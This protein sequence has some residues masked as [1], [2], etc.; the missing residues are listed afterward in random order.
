MLL[1][2]IAAVVLFSG[3]FLSCSKNYLDI[4]DKQN[5]TEQSFWQTRQNALEG[6]TATYAALQGYDGSKWTFFEEIYTTLT[7][8]SDDIEN[9]TV[10]SYGKSIASFTDGTDVSGVWNL[11]TTCYVGIGRANQVLEKV[12]SIEAMTEQE[13]KEIVG[14]ARFLRAYF[15]FVLING[16]ENVPLVLATEKDINKLKV[17]QASPDE[18]WTQIENDLL[19][20]EAALPSSYD[21][22]QIGRATQG[23]AKAMLGKVYLFREKWQAAETKFKELDGKYSL[24]NNY[25]DNFTGLRENSSESVFEIQFSGDRTLSDEMHPFNYEVRPYAI[26]GWELFYPSNWLVAEMKKDTTASGAYSSRVYNSIFFDDPQSKIWDLN[27]PA[28]EVSYSSLAG[29]LNHPHYFKKYAYPYDRSGSYTGVN[30]SLIRYADVLLMLAEALNENGK[31]DDA[32]GRINEVRARSGTKAI[33]NGSLTQAE[34]RELLRNH[35][36]PVELSMEFGIRWFDL[37]RWAK[38]ATAP[39]SIKSVLTIHNK[40]AA[41]NFIDNKHIRY[42]IPALERAVNPNLIQNNGY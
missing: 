34:C 40:P 11:W 6:I 21:D 42:A 37:I 26:D 19:E 31:T 13:R 22:S 5:I 14:E 41:A 4:A 25:E 33:E 8:R 7:Y 1:K 2:K 36:R 18:V 35:E 20:A 10:E 15:Y 28:N 38:G 3:L 24:L 29:T 9:N 30:I 27:V 12:P 39:I 16:F 23:A 32:I 17:P